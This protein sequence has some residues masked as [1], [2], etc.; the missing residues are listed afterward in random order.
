MR[1]QKNE[2]NY[3]C[4]LDLVQSLGELSTYAKQLKNKQKEKTDE[5]HV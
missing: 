5:I 2:L 4:K 1:R 3:L